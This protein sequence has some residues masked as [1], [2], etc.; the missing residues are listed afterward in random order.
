[1][2][3]LLKLVP[4]FATCG[5]QLISRYVKVDALVGQIIEGLQKAGL[6]DI[7]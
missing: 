1:V 4:D 3:Q 2:S 7:A 5:Q 6:S